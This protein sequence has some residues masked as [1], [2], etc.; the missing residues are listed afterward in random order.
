MRL[1]NEVSQNNLHNKLHPTV[2]SAAAVWAGRMSQ[3][4]GYQRR[5]DQKILAAYLDIVDSIYGVYLDSCQGFQS[6]VQVF[7]ASQLETLKRNIELSSQDKNKDIRYCITLDDLDSGCVI[8]SKGNEDNGAYRRLHYCPTQLEYKQR[9]NPNGGNYK[10]VGNMAIITI[11]EYWES[12][13]RNELAQLHQVKPKRIRSDIFGDLRHLRN[14]IIH[15]RG[16]ALPEVA[17]CKIFNWYNEGDE[18]FIC[19]D[20]MEDIVS[21]IKEPRSELYF[22]EGKAAQQ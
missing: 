4:F 13:C 10:F 9:N 11:F 22:V 20:K 18:I 5:M 14:S 21:A 6:A 1:E 3:T 16:I 12:S 15:H 8:Y 2:Q 19:G 17:K 7:E